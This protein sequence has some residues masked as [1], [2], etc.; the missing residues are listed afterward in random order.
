MRGEGEEGRYHSDAVCVNSALRCSADN[1][2]H[3]L[4]DQH[5]QMKRENGTRGVPGLCSVADGE[6][7]H[8]GLQPLLSDEDIDL[9]DLEDAVD[10]D[11][12]AEV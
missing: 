12:L 9:L 6:F 3:G 7:P 8:H 1:A 5:R 4:T 2:H 11:G 10:G